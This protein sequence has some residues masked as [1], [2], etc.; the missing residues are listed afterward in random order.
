MITEPLAHHEHLRLKD[1][2]KN[3]SNHDEAATNVQTHLDPVRNEPH[4]DEGAWIKKSIPDE[5]YNSLARY[6]AKHRA[7]EVNRGDEAIK[8]R[9]QA[10]DEALIS[11]LNT[12]KVDA[13]GRRRTTDGSQN[14]CS[15]CTTINFDKV[16]FDAD[17]WTSIK[18]D[19]LKL[20]PGTGV[21]IHM[22]PKLDADLLNSTCPLCRILAEMV[23]GAEAESMK[24]KLDSPSWHL[25]AV[26]DPVTEHVTIYLTEHWENVH[27]KK[28]PGRMGESRW[29]EC[30]RRGRLLP[31]SPS[32][33]D[34]N[35]PRVR[36]PYKGHPHESG[37]NFRRISQMLRDCERDHGNLCGLRLLDYP[38]RARVIDCNN[39]VVMPLT[40]DMEY[41]ALSYVWGPQPQLQ[42][43]TI[44]STSQW[45]LPEQLPQTIEDS[46][47]VMKGL[48]L[49]YLWVD[50]YCI[51][52][53]HATDKQFQ[54]GQMAKIY[55]AAFAT[56]CALGDHDDYGLHGVS[57][58]RKP[59]YFLDHK[60]GKVARVA[61]AQRIKTFLM[62][63][64]WHERGWT[65][66]EIF[67]SR[68]AL[69]FTSE[70][71]FMVCKEMCTSE[72]LSVAFGDEHSKKVRIEPDRLFWAA[73]RY[74][75]KAETIPLFEKQVQEYQSRK[76]KFRSDMLFAFEGLLSVQELSTIM[77]VPVMKLPPKRY[78]SE[79]LIKYGFAYGL[80]WRHTATSG[81]QHRP[82]C[83]GHRCSDLDCEDDYIAQFPSWSWVCRPATCT[84][85]EY[86][87][88]PRH[89]TIKS[90]YDPPRG[91]IMD[92]LFCADILTQTDT[93]TQSITA[94]LAPLVRSH[95]DKAITDG[96]RRLH[97]TSVI[98]QWSGTKEERVEMY[99]QGRRPSRW[100]KH[101]LPYWLDYDKGHGGWSGI[102]KGGFLG[103]LHFD[104]P[105]RHKERREGLAMLLFA[106]GMKDCAKGCEILYQRTN[107][108]HLAR[109]V[110]LVIR[111]IGDG[112]YRREGLIESHGTM[113][114]SATRKAAE[115]KLDIPSDLKTI[116]LS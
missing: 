29:F 116:V 18:L 11:L 23:Y 24:D 9:T 73:F 92:V 32:A 51:Q 84:R 45:G 88:R 48:G 99:I 7:E 62:K 106:T 46:I 59:N 57:L 26:K 72:G 89:P 5:A 68:R 108:G 10:R 113:R 16:F 14:L 36:Q 77:G 103:V 8:K 80:A 63:S 109:L 37:V 30:M 85:F 81:L 19:A 107:H 87:S 91:A 83:D 98:A 71:T 40:T 101:R 41:I 110:W 94:F 64:V 78:D 115:G 35:G 20:G 43:Q 38:V 102:D 86:F 49:R 104:H 96:P 112:T 65:Y 27:E 47:A 1:P 97:L 6:L 105:T 90:R 34:L 31:C 2:V 75:P 17:V 54:I 55:G 111:D 70:E 52:Q 50:R 76:L 79:L 3:V 56:I 39:R 67:L 93:K 15:S 66:Q 28:G 114:P 61:D 53:V 13:T 25:R 100:S 58:P 4:T 21:P 82:G 74:G 12:F 22:I 95:Q 44:A 60:G 33:F 42:S 69:F